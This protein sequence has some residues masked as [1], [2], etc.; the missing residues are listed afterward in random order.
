MGI[1]WIK[2]YELSDNNNKIAGTLFEKFVLDYLNHC[3]KGYDWKKTKSSWDNNR[4]FISLILENIWAEAKYK[5]DCTALKKSD[6]DP[7]MISGFLNGKIEVILFLT[8][9][10]LPN[11]LMNRIQQAEKMRFFRVICITKKQLEYWLYLH[12]DIY[13]KY[14]H[15]ELTSTDE[16]LDAALITKI[17]IIDPI[18]SNNNLV[19]TTQEL[20]NQHFYVLFIT[21]ESNITAPI[22][23]LDNTYPFSFIDSIGYENHKCVRI[24]PGI[25]QFKFL[26]YTHTYYDGALELRYMLNDK[27]PL[28]FAFNLN[29][30]MDFEMRLVYSQQ[31]FYKERIIRMLSDKNANERLITLGGSSGFGKTHLLKDILQHFY[32]SRQIMYFCFYP[33]K[34]YR[35]AIEI[36]RLIIYINFGEIANYF[37]KETSIDT[38]DYYKELLKEQFDSKNA[39]LNLILETIDG[40]YDEIHAQNIK[41]SILSDIQFIAKVILHR[42]DPLAHLALLDNT[43]Q[44]N[45]PE[46]SIIENII[47]YS[48]C[49][50]STRFLINSKRTEND[51][52]FYLTGLTVND[53]K[54]SLLKNFANWKPSFIEVIYKEMP[55]CP[56]SFIDIIEVFKCY[57]NQ[58]ND[59]D[60]IE[61]YIHLSDAAKSTT[62][63]KT[64]FMLDN[65]YLKILFFIYLFEDGIPY[66][67]LYNLDISDEQLTTLRDHQYIKNSCGNVKAFS[68]L[69]R[70]IFLKENRSKCTDFIKHCFK[71]ISDNAAK[72]QEYIFLPEL[73]EKCIEYLD[74]SATV[75]STDLLKNMRTCSYTCDYKNMY[76]YGK[77]AYYFLS[78]KTIAELSETDYMILFYYGISLLHCDR[79]RGAI[80]I[81]RKIKNNASADFHVNFMA[82]CEL[83]N[84]LYNRFQISELEGEMLITLMELK[85]KI[86]SIIDES[87]DLALD[88]RIAYSTCMNRYMMVLFT[89]DR[90]SDATAVLNQYIKYSK[91]IPYSLYSNKYSSMI[92]EWFLDYA[93]GIFWV[94]PKCA[95]KYY[96]KSI[97][98][99]ENGKNEKRYL[100]AKIDLAFL[101]CVYFEEYAEIETIH[102]LTI[103]LQKKNYINE[104]FRGIIRENLCK[105]VQYFTDPYIANSKGLITTAQKMKEDALNIELDS[106]LYINGHLA[107]QTGLYFSVI[108]SIIQDYAE[109]RKYLEHNLHMISEAGNSFKNIILHNLKY[110]NQMKTIE[111]G[112]TE[113][114]YSQYSFILDPRIW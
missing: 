92:G 44:L 66:K 89:Q 21:I 39:D 62:L 82:S 109:A 71:E 57:L 65:Q 45:P 104:Y 30:C 64:K 43:E 49:H 90:I 35:N 56:A 10:Y 20:Y 4:D 72:Y 15:E 16:S 27:S 75:I 40:C 84:N 18:N 6:I 111:W 67:V 3:Y 79:K 28:S 14:F 78:Q 76:I 17:E 22:A 93:R 74:D 54:N 99:L 60:I 29:I 91:T 13:K 9:G 34:D 46:Y 61:K 88:T 51:C 95:K 36:C 26:I 87:D 100:L 94:D 58:G 81:F 112:K 1:N 101:K 37:K 70:N 68:N 7:T 12:P 2:L 110:C 98:L 5:K 97:E 11:T 8:N 31:L 80:E 50:N 24:R 47:K 41:K 107:Y 25:Q 23:I 53:I 69:Y 85:R 52:D 42:T 106:M 103:T 102:N 77:I 114:T 33:H 113:R 32:A 108:D 19:A 38:I 83:Y 59:M 105:L 55:C 96:K 63:Y 48:I 73:Y 86:D